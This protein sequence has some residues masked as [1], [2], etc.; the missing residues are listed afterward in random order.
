MKTKDTTIK[1]RLL[2]LTAT[3]LLLVF[4]LILGEIYCRL[5]TRINFLD[6]SKG[7]FA[8]G[9]YGKTY[10]NVPN[11]AGV[12]FGQKFVTDADGFRVSE[13]NQPPNRASESILI[14]G[15]SVSFG[16]A[17]AEPQTLAG[18][19]AA[20]V[21]PEFKIINASAIGYDT[22]DY[23]NVV[24]ALVD[25]QPAIKKVWLFFCLNDVNEVSA[26][27]IKRE[28][29][30][31]RNPEESA[32]KSAG[33]TINDFLRSRSKLYLWLKNALRDTQLIYFENDLSQYRQD[34]AD[35]A[36]ALKP[37]AEIKAKLEQKGISFEVFV[38]PYEAQTRPNAPPEYLLPQHKVDR[39]LAE[40]NINFYDLTAAFQQSAAPRLLFLYGDPMHLSADGHLLTADLV[41][42]GL[43]EVCKM[44]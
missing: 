39:F 5:F 4:P 40:N 3:C 7:M 26:Q 28:L 8:L 15:D 34:D 18:I 6:N 20:R 13:T 25:R 30:G 1:K 21:A 32:E 41:C 23:Q 17:V 31:A 35:I 14:I 44:N 38:L 36:E 11:F 9:R 2:L 24:N 37:L 19:L 43:K 10:G 12:S 42:A 16:A 27:Q 29:N 22:Y 33:Q